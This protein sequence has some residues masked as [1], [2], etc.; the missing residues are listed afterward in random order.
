MPDIH[1]RIRE[2]LMNKEIELWTA[3]TSAEPA[4]P[5]IKLSNPEANFLF[6]KKGSPHP[7][8]RAQISQGFETSFPSIR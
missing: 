2:D 4:P 7:A 8:R 6:P 1:D 3:L 5:I